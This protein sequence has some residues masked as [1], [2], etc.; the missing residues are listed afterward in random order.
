MRV[1]VITGPNLNLLGSR[2]PE[3][4]GTATL[5]DCINVVKKAMPN[6][7]VSDFQSND[8]GALINTIHDAR[9]NQD[10]II[11]NAGAYSHY[12]HAIRDALELFDGIK[13]EVHLSNP[14]AR[15]EFRR[16]SVISP[17]VDGVIAGFKI[18]SY[19]L[20]AQAIE[21]LSKG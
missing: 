14:Y 6:E 10:A 3:I 21:A 12:S 20:A 13:V 15:E 19:L 11:I 16:T 1:L 2:D 17:A 18:N 5:Q 7:N 4:Y 9:N 8:E